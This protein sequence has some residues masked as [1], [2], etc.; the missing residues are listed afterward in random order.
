MHVQRLRGG[1][2]NEKICL[3]WRLEKDFPR[4][5]EIRREGDDIVDALRN[6]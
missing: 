1:V 2:G 5:G 6:K 3:V 4:D